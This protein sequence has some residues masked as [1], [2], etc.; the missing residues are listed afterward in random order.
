[1]VIQDFI[2]NAID[3][4]NTSLG[5]NKA[6]FGKNVEIPMSLINDRYR[7]VIDSVV[8]VFG[9][10][11]S[12][13][14]AFNMLGKLL[15]HTMEIE[16]PLKD[17]LEKLCESTVNST[18][19]VPRETII[20]ECRLVDK[21]KPNIPLRIM[22]EYSDNEYTFSDVH[23]DNNDE[24]LKRR[25][26]DSMIQ[27]VSYLLMMATYDNE[28]IKDWNEELPSLYEKIISLN[29]FLLF[30]KEES[31]NDKDPMLG[32][33]VET[34]LGNED[35]RTI[36]ESQGLIYP[37][38]LQETYRGFFEMF[39][40]NGLP[41][42]LNDTLNIIKKADI[43]IAEAWDL[44]LGVPIWQRIDKHIPN[45]VETGMYPYIF[46]SI[47]SQPTKEFNHTVY[48]LMLKDN[49]INEWI[50]DIISQVKHDEEYNT[51]KRDIDRFNLEKSLITDSNE[52]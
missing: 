7:Q 3:N 33:H 9:K 43:T 2:K 47:V 37:L 49:G 16:N 29:D 48:R 46:S 25:L 44:R 11:P 51:F 21:I 39:A 12:V 18:L 19:S 50:N 17:Q 28:K 32:A 52:G 24:I 42:N 30:N 8:R 4:E 45:D 20:L 35:D 1:M 10:V 27:G 22:P 41:D 6:F 23:L 14:E 31:I 34:I 36:I 40:S 13:D 26:I 5:S 38:L 15:K